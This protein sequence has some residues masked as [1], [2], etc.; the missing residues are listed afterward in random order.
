LF[1]VFQFSFNSG[2]FICVSFKKVNLND[3]DSEQKICRGTAIEESKERVR[4]STSEERVSIWSLS[5]E[6][7][8]SGVLKIFGNGNGVEKDCFE[9]AESLMEKIAEVGI[10]KI[11]I[12]G[13]GDGKDVWKGNRNDREKRKYENEWD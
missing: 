10:E 1:D 2:F 7:W 4:R 3:A 12:G 9:D 13:N 8:E 11:V 6:I 5:A